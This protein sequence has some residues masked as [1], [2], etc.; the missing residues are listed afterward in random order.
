MALNT[1][2]TFPEKELGL[3]GNLDYTWNFTTHWPELT[4]D[5]LENMTGV[6]LVTKKR[7]STEQAE[8]ELKKVSR[9]SK[10]F[11][12]N[13]ILS[14]SKPLLEYMVAKDQEKLYEVLEYQVHIFEAGFVDGGWISMYETTDQNSAKS[15][16]G[17]AAEM[18][19]S[20]SNLSRKR[21]NFYVDKAVIRSDY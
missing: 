20:S 19:L 1:E 18:F 14:N 10:L 15:S 4:L 8:I 9:L 7:G 2:F 5:Y 21:L 6:N 3:Y 16:I 12:F 11:L 17:Q 13:K